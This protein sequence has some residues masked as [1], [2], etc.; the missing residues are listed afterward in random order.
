MTV[1]IENTTGF[2]LIPEFTWFYNDIAISTNSSNPNISN[3][4]YIVF[5]SVN[6]IQ[7][8]NYSIIAVTEGG[9]STGYFTL[10][11]LCKPYCQYVVY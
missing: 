4:P 11:V 6:H 3:Y 1:N 7:S 10:D 8:G 5:T 2:P 9:N